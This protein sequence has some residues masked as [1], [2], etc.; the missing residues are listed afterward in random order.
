[1][2]VTIDNP[3]QIVFILFGVAAVVF[4]VMNSKS[5]DN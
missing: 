5:D 3:I 1:M 4:M 2:S